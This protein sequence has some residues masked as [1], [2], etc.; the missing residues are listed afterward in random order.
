MT[1]CLLGKVGYSCGFCIW[2]WFFFF[3][4]CLSLPPNVKLHVM[5]VW[6]SFIMKVASKCCS[7]LSGGENT[8]LWLHG[9]DYQDLTAAGRN[10]WKC[11]SEAEV[12]QIHIHTQTW[13]NT[14]LAK[15]CSQLPSHAVF[16]LFFFWQHNKRM[17]HSSGWPW[18][19]LLQLS[20]CLLQHSP[21]PQHQDEVK[22]NICKTAGQRRHWETAVSGPG[23]SSQG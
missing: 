12:H 9:E 15:G 3:G 6:E 7:N 21:G 5:S 2:H 4:V 19:E 16:C 17:C 14:Y 20:S 1:E 13:G 10:K 11:G 8:P 22:K 18:R 23:E